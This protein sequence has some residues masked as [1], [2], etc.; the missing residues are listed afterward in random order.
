MKCILKHVI[1]G[2]IERMIEMKRKRGVRHG[3]LPDDLKGKRGHCKW[4]EEA[5]N[6]TVWRTGFGRCCGPVVRQSKQCI[7][8]QEN[9]KVLHLGVS[10][11]WW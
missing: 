11:V 6:R 5:L 8:L 7:N 1:E 10:F 9:N 3:Q 2:N 4:K